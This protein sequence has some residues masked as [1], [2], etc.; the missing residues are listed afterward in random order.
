MLLDK[1]ATVAHSVEEHGDAWED[2]WTVLHFAVRGG[3]I[4]AVRHL[5]ALPAGRALVNQPSKT[6][7]TPLLHACFFNEGS[8]VRELCRAGARLDLPFGT[9]YGSHS[10][11][12][13]E[14]E[15]NA[16]FAGRLPLHWAYEN[17][18]YQRAWFYPSPELAG[19]QQQVN[20]AG[21]GAA[22]VLLAEVAW[23]PAT[24]VLLHPG[25]RARAVA[26]LRLGY[27]LARHLAASQP[28]LAAREAALTCLWVEAVMPHAMHD[29][30][31][32]CGLSILCDR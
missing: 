27:H 22:R 29:S 4:E 19:E 23:S 3:S 10:S 9:S 30:Q 11:K 32:G 20:D 1:G 24:H 7:Q 12:Q 6:S 13:L 5:L 26:L 31:R 25:A 2:G 21:R 18:E 14:T 16:S 28:T 17:P 15:S 8:M